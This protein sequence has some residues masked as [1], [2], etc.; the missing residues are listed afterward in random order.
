[1]SP[2]DAMSDPKIKVEVRGSD[3]IATMPGTTFNATYRRRDPGIERLN[4]G[5]S[6]LGAP[7]SLRE[8]IVLADDAANE[9][10]RQLGWIV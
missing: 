3:T 10:A 9:K 5:R 6:D 1:M 4:F 8:F 7:I 2:Q